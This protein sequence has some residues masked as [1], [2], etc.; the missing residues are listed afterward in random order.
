VWAVDSGDETR[1]STLQRRYNRVEEER[2]QLKELFDL[3]RDQPDT[4][5]HEIFRRLRTSSNPLH[6]FRD[7]RQANLLLPNPDPVSQVIGNPQVGAI[8]SEA[9]RLSALKLRA[10]PWTTVA[11]DGLVS[12]LISSFFAWDGN[13]LTPFV[14]SKCFIKAMNTGNV[15]SIEFC[16]P[17]LVNAIC[18]ISVS[19]NPTSRG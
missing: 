3:I 8:D 19:A 11:G 4:E 18:C 13:Y 16:S 10:R 7:L 15:V 9:L 17:F 5:A 2:D 6:V 1:R 14:D 12:A